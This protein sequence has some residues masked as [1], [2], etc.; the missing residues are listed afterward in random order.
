MASYVSNPVSF[1]GLPAVHL[2]SN[3]VGFTAL[4]AQH[5]VSNPVT[6]TAPSA[7][8]MVRQG[9]TLMPARLGVR[10]GN[11]IQWLGPPL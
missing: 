4:P 8:F 1:T 11:T 10:V 3:P 2:V 6:F 9:S 7:Y 5:I